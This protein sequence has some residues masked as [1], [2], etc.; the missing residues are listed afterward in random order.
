[1]FF[2][3]FYL[4]CY[5]L[6][7]NYSDIIIEHCTFLRSASHTHP[8]LHKNLDSFSYREQPEVLGKLPSG[9]VITTD[10]PVYCHGIKTKTPK[11]LI[12]SSLVP[13]NKKQKTQTTDS[14]FI[15]KKL[16][17]VILFIALD[18]LLQKK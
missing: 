6:T 11:P 8:L 15:N 5:S 2:H 4:S 17:I 7:Y 1:M 12:V 3:Y 16:N 18:V 10:C 13:W 14:I 9:Q